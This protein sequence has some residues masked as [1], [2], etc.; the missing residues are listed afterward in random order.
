V[1]P[2]TAT[3][4]AT[5]AGP[6]TTLPPEPTTTVPP[7][8]EDPELSPSGRLITGASRSDGALLIGDAVFARTVDGESH[9]FGLDGNGQEVFVGAEGFDGL[10]TVLRI[11]DE[12]GN[13]VASNDDI[14]DADGN[15]VSRDPLVTVTIPS[16]QTFTAEVVPFDGTSSGSF[17]LFMDPVGSG[18]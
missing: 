18:E 12:D 4:T 8:P 16:G 14:Q 5:T 7:A 2:T 15:A 10:D 6:T 17:V 9:I 11:R 1:A 13:V 3:T